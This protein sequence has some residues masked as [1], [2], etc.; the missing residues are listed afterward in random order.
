[1]TITTSKYLKEEISDY[2]LIPLEVSALNISNQILLNL[3]TIEEFLKFA[4][5]SKFEYVYYYYTYYNPEEYIIPLNWYSEYSDEF[6]AVVGKHNQY[7]ESLDFDSPKSL[8]LFVLQN[9]TFVG[10]KLDNSW[11]ESI[12]VNNAEDAIEEIESE[13][14]REVNKVSASKKDRK[15]EDENKLIEMVFNDPEFKYCKNQTLRY[16]YLV[17]LLENESM[18][19]YRYLVEPYGIPRDGKIKLFMDKAWI[20]YKELKV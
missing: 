7:I 17:E 2:H 4:S 14:Y 6:K 20:L 13:F 9:G 5:V 1:M 10:M 3:D 15:K 12:G 11:I 8:T 16:W 19:K 18:E